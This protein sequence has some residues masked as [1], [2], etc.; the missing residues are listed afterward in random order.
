MDNIRINPQD[1]TPSE[2]EHAYSL[3][4]INKEEYLDILEE[5]IVFH[6]GIIG[7]EIYESR[8]EQDHFAPL[9]NRPE[10]N[11]E[12]EFR[13]LLIE[14]FI[15]LGWGIRNHITD[16]EINEVL[17]KGSTIYSQIRDD[18]DEFNVVK[19]AKP[20][21]IIWRGD[22][23]AW[24]NV[25]NV[26]AP[27]I[28]N[29]SPVRWASHFCN[30]SGGN[31][32]PPIVLEDSMA[33]SRSSKGKPRK[34]VEE[35]RNPLYEEG[36]FEPLQWRNGQNAFEQ[37]YVRLSKHLISANPKVWVSH[38]KGYDGL[39]L[40]APKRIKRQKKSQS[41]DPFASNAILE[42]MLINEALEK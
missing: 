16:D 17:N 33:M 24:C 11:L 13:L 27:L 10:M 5:A 14:T 23:D 15:S 40:V 36:D 39:R 42:I 30:K 41:R 38:F 26:I 21:P 7:N 28:A 4:K 6:K 22:I 9:V 25:Y 2:L 35:W 3:R 12:I 20:L 32:D 1:C 18:G 37:I 19:M 29:A 31:M 8:K 34:L